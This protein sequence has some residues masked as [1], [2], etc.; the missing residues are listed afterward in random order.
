MTRNFSRRTLA[1]LAIAG[2]IAAPAT[3]SSDATGSVPADD[4]PTVALIVNSTLG[5]GGF[6]DN[7]ARGVQEEGDRLGIEYQVIETGNDPSRWEPA[8]QDS[9]DR[10]DVVIAGTFE[11]L[12]IV[13]RAATEH[14]DTQFVLFDIASDPEACGCQNIYSIVYRNRESGFLAGALSGLL[15]A[16]PD[17]ERLNDDLVVGVVGGL[18]IPVITD[19]IEGFEAGVAHTNPE[20]EVLTAFAGSFSDPAKGKAVAEEMIGQGADIVFT[21]AGGTDGGVFEAAAAEGVWAIGNSD[22]H[23]AEDGV[24]TSSATDVGASMIDAMQ[25][26]AAGDL[27]VGET[28]SFGVAEDTNFIVESDAYLEFVPESVRDQMATILADVASGTISI[29]Q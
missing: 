11:L 6:F 18:E 22:L 14:P 29:E 23:T 13:E 8:V 17:V 20:V 28:V 26:A 1:A 27:P 25:R 9:A 24:L 21:A 2:V 19:Y 4:L 5:D 10:F 7:L 15:E 3:G 12:E 16:E